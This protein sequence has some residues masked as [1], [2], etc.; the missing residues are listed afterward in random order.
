MRSHALVASGWGASQPGLKG[1]EGLV[2]RVHPPPKLLRRLIL[3]QDGHVPCTCSVLIRRS[4]IE[5]VGGFEEGFRLY[6][7]QAL[8]VK[9]FLHYPTYVIPVCLSRYRQHPGSVSAAATERGLYNR[10]SM[11]PSRGLFLAWLAAYVAE[12]GVKDRRLSRAIRLARAPYVH[13]RTLQ[14][15]ADRFALKATMEC[16]KVRR[17][18]M[19]SGCR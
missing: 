3:M 9:L 13:A 4:A 8:W 11:H 6:E 10:M 12:N 14:N 7:D 5:F 17:Y 15:G 2:G 16:A 18:F 19:R 1:L